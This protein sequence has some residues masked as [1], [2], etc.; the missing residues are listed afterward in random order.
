MF[1]RVARGAVLKTAKNFSTTSQVCQYWNLQIYVIVLIANNLSP[2]NNARVAVCGAAGG[3]GQPLSLLLKQSPL[4]TDLRLFDIVH[5]PGVA[6]DLSH[7][8]TPSKV[9]GLNGPE[10]VEKILEGR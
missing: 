2:Q 6:A 8:D 7:I 3:I 1:N 4:V 10:N 9:M 5:T